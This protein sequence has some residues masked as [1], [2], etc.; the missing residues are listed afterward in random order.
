MCATS[1]RRA[2]G[3]LCSGSR[4]IEP[5]PPCGLP[6]RMCVFHSNAIVTHAYI[7]YLLYFSFSSLPTIAW[8]PI[9]IRCRYR[10]RVGLNTPGDDTLC[11]NTCRRVVYIESRLCNQTTIY[12]GYLNHGN[13]SVARRCYSLVVSKPRSYR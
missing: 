1:L 3:I 6:I 9:T 13:V 5:S 8:L 10:N 2:I 12:N 7:L 11:A 4:I